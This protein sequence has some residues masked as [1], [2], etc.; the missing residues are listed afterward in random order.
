MFP[1]TKC[2][3]FQKWMW[4]IFKCGSVILCR[5][6]SP[7]SNG[8]FLVIYLF[9]LTAHTIKK[10]KVL[11]YIKLKFTKNKQTKNN[12][13][14]LNLHVICSKIQFKNCNLTHLQV[15]T[16]F[17]C[18]VHLD[19]IKSCYQLHL[20]LLLNPHAMYALVIAI[21][22]LIKCDHKVNCNKGIIKHDTFN[23]QC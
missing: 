13:T 23:V 10:S 5:C 21:H 14:K 18:K 15:V 11:D 2:I 3:N 4:I 20:Q 12:F 22:D 9:F 1:I 19:G 6:G 8:I 16:K 7:C 17:N